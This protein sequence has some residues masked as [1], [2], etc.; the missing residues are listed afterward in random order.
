MRARGQAVTLEA[1]EDD[2]RRRDARDS[3]RANAPL[4]QAEEAMVLDNSNL[5]PEESI[6]EALR[7]VER[8]LDR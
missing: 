1:I 3:G 4:R 2:L 8:A 5:S 6:A 7:L